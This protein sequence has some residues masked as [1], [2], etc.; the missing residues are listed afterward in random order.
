MGIVLDQGKK[1]EA[2][3]GR[4]PVE[5]M[6]RLTGRDVP[7]AK[8][9]SSP[10]KRPDDK[11]TDQPDRYQKGV[12]LILESLTRSSEPVTIITV[13]SLRDVAAACNRR[14]DLFRRKVAKLLVFIGAADPDVREYNVDLDRNAFVRIMNSGL[15]VWW[16][17][18]FDGGLFRNQGNASFWRAKHA[19]LLRDASDRV[20]SYF[21]FALRKKTDPDHLGF[22]DRKV[23][24]QDRARVLSGTR[25]LWC[26]AVFTHVAGLEIV[27]QGDGWSALPSGA[28]AED[29]SVVEAFRF[30]PVSLHV[31]GEARVVYGESSR[32]HRVHR[33]QVVNRKLYPSIMTAVTRECGCGEWEENHEGEGEQK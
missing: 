18:C 13:G 8:G 22:L 4:I 1:Q 21:V 27:R 25:N 14:P 26:A 33:F 31:D 32:S 10:L 2:R 28:V 7:W 30:V 11:A 6:N 17:P 20:M 5:Q 19:D 12:R 3:P 24:A 9:L 15:P 29:S 23:T 16:V